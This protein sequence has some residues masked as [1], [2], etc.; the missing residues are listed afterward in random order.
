MAANL[1]IKGA[2]RDLVCLVNIQLQLLNRYHSGTLRFHLDSPQAP[3][4]GTD[5]RTRKT[6]SSRGGGESDDRYLRWHLLPAPADPGPASVTGHH[7][8]PSGRFLRQL[9]R[10]PV[11]LLR[12]PPHVQ[13]EAE[14]GRVKPESHSR[15]LLCLHASRPPDRHANTD[16]RFTLEHG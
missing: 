9:A 8:S 13:R 14:A 10:L 16:L 5:P 1:L 12:R 4:S 6:K 3:A 15:T 7:F 2:L 11:A